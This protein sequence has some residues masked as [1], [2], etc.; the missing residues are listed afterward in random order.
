MKTFCR[1]LIFIFAFVLF[2]LAGKLSFGQLITNNTGSSSVLQRE[3]NRQITGIFIMPV[4]SDTSAALA[5]MDSMGMMIQIRTTGKMYKRDTANPGH[6]WTEI[7]SGAGGVFVDSVKRK[8]GTDSLF[9]YISGASHFAGRDT[10]SLAY[11]LVTLGYVPLSQGDSVAVIGF[12]PRGQLDTSRRNI[13]AAIFPKLDSVRRV[14]GKDSVYEYFGGGQKRF[15]YRDSIGSGGGGSI[16][17]AITQV[18]Y[19]S[20][21]NAVKGESAFTYDET[22]NTITT[23]SIKGKTGRFD[24]SS[25]GTIQY[26]IEVFSSFGG[27]SGGF[28]QNTSTSGSAAT[29]IVLRSP[30]GHELQLSQLGESFATAATVIS[31]TSHSD[32]VIRADSGNMVFEMGPVGGLIGELI[33]FWYPSSNMGIGRLLGFANQQYDH[34]YQVFIGKT[35]TASDTGALL[36]SH[37]IDI[38][39]EGSGFAVLGA[40]NYLG[41]TLYV[42]GAGIEL[43]AYT[44]ANHRFAIVRFDTTGTMNARGGVCAGCHYSLADIDAS[45]IMQARSTTKGFAMPV[46]TDAQMKA[47]SSPT[48]GLQVYNTDF[49]QVYRYNTSYGNWTL[50]PSDLDLYTPTTGASQRVIANN[51]SVFNPAGTIAALTVITPF[52]PKKGDY[53]EIKFEQIVTTITWTGTWVS[54]PTTVAAGTYLKFQFDGTNWY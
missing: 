6:K 27:Y 31:S 34:H 29:R 36:T 15:A 21:T 10:L 52:N 39:D 25:S 30:G 11:L 47:I 7:S 1:F 43:T 8:L 26:P 38:G 9:Y 19:G 5:K 12:V 40:Y 16:S 48:N 51:Y 14:P 18:A 42:Q 17:I 44:K 28:F 50:N 2:L 22:S 45:A 24:G 4:V 20:G 54:P 41:D 37:R 35:P 46:M 13:Y 32:F 53:V 3:P 23:D 33:R 49:N